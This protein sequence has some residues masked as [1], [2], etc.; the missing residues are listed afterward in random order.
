[1]N[2]VNVLIDN[3]FKKGGTDPSEALPDADPLAFSGWLCTEI[4]QFERLL[5]GVSDLGAYGAA[6]GLTCT[7]Q[8]ASCDHLKV[9]GKPPH[10]FP[11]VDNVR[12]AVRDSLC[13]NVVSWL[14]KKFWAK[15]GR[16]IAS[17]VGMASTQEVT[18]GVFVFSFYLFSHVLFGNSLMIAI[19][20]MGWDNLHDRN[21]F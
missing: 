4:G 5:S 10:K 14:L 2:E 3:A 17:Y 19:A 21:F 16:A 13:K 20:A 15:G 6:L 7:F 1:M 9:L 12:E 11:S 8:V 18:F